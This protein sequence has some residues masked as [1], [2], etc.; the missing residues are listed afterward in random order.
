MS[1]LHKRVAKVISG[2][3]FI[4]LLFCGIGALAA[5]P[6]P[7]SLTVNLVR[8]DELLLH[9]G[10]IT[11]PRPNMGI[12]MFTEVFEG[13]WLQVVSGQE[14]LAVLPL[15]ESG[16]FARVAY[17]GDSQNDGRKLLPVAY[18]I[19]DLDSI[20]E[21]MTL[22]NAEAAALCSYRVLPEQP[23]YDEAFASAP[24]GRALYPELDALLEA[25]AGE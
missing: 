25:L 2:L 24:D 17:F 22:E 11:A 15:D 5:D 8:I 4:C 1:C 21:E 16:Q 20:P 18:V 3:L 6:E 19:F 13:L 9:V 12:A 7:V 10:E 14:E 23:S